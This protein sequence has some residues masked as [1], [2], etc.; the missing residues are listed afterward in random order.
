MSIFS[1]LGVR[2]GKDR[3]NEE[4]LYNLAACYALA[5]RR[6]EQAL[7]PFGLSAVKMNALM[8]L[9]H[10]GG[11]DGMPQVD[12]AR[13]M[14]VSAGNV[15]RL[16]DR[17]E[18]EKLVAR[19]AREGDRRVKALKITPKG[20]ELMTRA[21]PVHQREVDRAVSLMRGKDVKSAC[22]V[23]NDFREQLSKTDA[24]EA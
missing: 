5:E 14:I 3:Q 23:L 4:F 12:L 2:E 20:S 8:I 11:K 13:R 10:V 17:L 9:K 18:K 15:T 19:V 21:W 16:I 6:I 22:A 24:Q 7:S 1:E